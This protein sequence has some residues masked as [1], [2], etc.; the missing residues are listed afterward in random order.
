MIRVR[1]V[2]VPAW[3]QLPGGKPLVLKCSGVG[4][5]QGL[6]AVQSILLQLLTTI[7]PG[8]LKMTFIDP[9]GLG[10]KAAPFMHL[11]DYDDQ[12]VTGKVW[13][14]PQHIEQ[15]LAELTQH[16]EN[17][18]QQYLRDKFRS[19]EDYNAQAGEIAE[20][21]RVLAVFDFPVNFTDDA[22]RRIVSI[23]QNGPR[24]GVY[25]IILV[26]TQKPL[27]YGFN[28]ADLEQHA[29]VLIWER[30]HW[31]W[32]HPDFNS[33][34]LELDQPPDTELFNRIVIAVGEAA[35]EA[36]KVEVP[37]ERIA[38][39]EET[40]WTQDSRS[41]IRVPLGPCG[42]RRVQELVLGHGMA[43]HVLVA[44]RTGSGKS[45]LLHTIITSLA[46]SYSPEELELYLIDFKKGVEFKTYVSYQLPH[47]RVVAI[48]SEREFGLSVLQR[49]AAELDRRGA[50]FR[51]EGVDHIA[52]YRQ[53]TGSRLPRILL[54]V[55]E[56]HEFFTEDDNIASQAA[57]ILDRLVRQGRAFGVHILLSSQTLAGTYT[58]SRGTVDQ[59]GVRIALQCSEADS[60]MILAEDNPAARLLSRPGEAIYNDKNGLV[61]G[62]SRFQVAWLPDDQRDRYL[63]SI[64]QLASRNGYRP[65]QP[66]IV[67][68]GNAPADVEKNSLLQELVMAP[69]WP[70]R[71]DS[72]SAWLGEPLAIKD[73]LAA[74]FKCESGKNLLIVGQNNEAALGMMI[75]ALVSLA[76][77]YP[78][79]AAEFYFLDFG[80]PES[81][82]KE[83]IGRLH[84]LFP[85]PFHLVR[86]RESPK[87]ITRINELLQQRLDTEE[88]TGPNVYLFLYALQR[89]R[90]FQQDELGFLGL[91]NFSSAPPASPSP[92]QQ[93]TALLRDGPQKGIHTLLWCDTL[94]NFLRRLDRR[95]LPDFGMRVVFQ[96][97][98]E[99]SAN[100]IDTPAANRLGP[101]R[102]F[103]YEEYGSQLTKFRPYTI[104]PQE[105]LSQVKQM[106]SQ[107]SLRNLL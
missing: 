87:T 85:H 29:E 3:I 86:P 65:P 15:R 75:V 20:P 104:P 70:Q 26:D 96:M 83:V 34:I 43:Q 19:I 51:A 91:G 18:I 55:D 84:D 105:W 63:F 8:K 25:A 30:V 92:A 98:N 33:V 22:A 58:L 89:A 35:K 7:P 71:R 97:S 13:T 103:F 64:Q 69:H 88:S 81:S 37:F 99:D 73:S 72:V 45:T 48:E 61:E 42:A 50:L 40:W 14:E 31:V 23:V 41:E 102:A 68:E 24:C 101:Y 56:F 59:I 76:A 21:Y 95:V 44:G 36:G 2:L 57:Q 32:Q 79:S 100:L 11:A 54:L 46:V 90:D 4:E 10:E 17:V 9:V 62:N 49:L 106:F 77:H 27:P 1:K 53:K 5:K 93:L 16:M 80:F 78:P 38:P 74:L 12:L 47:A 28:M 39:S 82:H 6:Q 66:Q 67:F 60:R 94:T 52:T 107:K